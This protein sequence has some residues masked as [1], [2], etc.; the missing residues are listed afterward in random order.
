MEPRWNEID[1]G[2]PKDSGENLSQCHF[3][4][5]KSHMDWPRDRTQA[6]TVR[7]RRLTAWAMARPWIPLTQD[8]VPCD[9]PVNTGRAV[10]ITGKRIAALSVVLWFVTHGSLVGGYQHTTCLYKITASSSNSCQLWSSKRQV[11]SK[12]SYPPTR[13]RGV[14]TQKTKIWSIIDCGN[15]ET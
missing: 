3:V 9:T 14:T 10:R 8:S 6:S 1:R 11:P 15:L 4:H 13:L 5:H 12:R 7:G 2:K